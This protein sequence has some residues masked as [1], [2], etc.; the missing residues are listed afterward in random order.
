[1]SEQSRFEFQNSS[2]APEEITSKGCNSTTSDC[3]CAYPTDPVSSH[4][5][6][7]LTTSYALIIKEL[8]TSQVTIRWCIYV[9][10]NGSRSQPVDAG[11]N[12]SLTV[13]N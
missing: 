8:F 6:I 12:H 1:M 7:L 4:T 13:N 2:V 3:E 5:I 9:S 11:P 10:S